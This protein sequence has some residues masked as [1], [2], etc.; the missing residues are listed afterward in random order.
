MSGWKL[1]I[2]F[3]VPY[4]GVEVIKDYSGLALEVRV[5]F[6]DRASAQRAADHAEI[7]TRPGGPDIIQGTI[8]AGE[9]EAADDHS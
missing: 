5:P 2:R 8:V 9:I 6:A 7:T 1:V 4:V 3:P